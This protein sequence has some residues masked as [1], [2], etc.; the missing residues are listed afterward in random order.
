[1]QALKDYLKRIGF[2]HREIAQVWGISASC[3]YFWCTGRSKPNFNNR[4]MIERRTK[5]EV[6]FDDFD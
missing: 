1:M 4:I 3:V 2:T 5:G 6:K